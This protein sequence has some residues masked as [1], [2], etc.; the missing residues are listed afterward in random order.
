MSDTSTSHIKRLIIIGRR[1][2]TQHEHVAVEILIPG[3]ATLIEHQV[4]LYSHVEAIIYSVGY[5]VSI[6][7]YWSRY[8][9]HP[10]VPYGALRFSAKE[11]TSP[12]IALGT[13]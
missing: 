4:L 5:H 10:M 7:R 9:S 2:R 11:L 13:G 6:F 12:E 8:K 1:R 3:I